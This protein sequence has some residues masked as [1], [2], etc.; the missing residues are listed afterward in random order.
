MAIENNN[1][2]L[3]LAGGKG[4]RL[5]PSSRNDEPKQFLDFFGMGRTQ[6]QQTYDRFA[7]IVPQDHI[8]ISTI[9]NYIHFVVDQLPDVDGNHILAEPVH[10]NTAPSVA[11]ACHRILHFNP[12]ANIIV[13][14]S[15]QT[16]MDEKAF[17]ANI[18]EGLHFVDTNDSLLTL[19]VKP[20]RPEPGY[21]Y[22]QVGESSG[23]DDIYKVKAFTEKPEREFA[24]MFVQSGE[25]Y[26]NTGMFLSNAKYLAKCLKKFLP[27][28]FANFDEIRPDWTIVEENIYVEKHFPSFPNIS[29]D[30][31][32]LEKSDNVYVQKCDFGWADLGT[33]H[34]IYAAENKS[35]NGN[36]TV[37]TKA[38][39]DDARNNVVKLPHDRI[40]VING[41]DGYIVAEK[42]NVLLIC[43][44]GDSSS[45]IKKYVNDIQLRLGEEYV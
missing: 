2:C 19:G 7:Q 37:D 12:N 3:I 8:Y 31:G 18:L 23:E 15:D 45:L 17:K 40:G 26:W 11:W 22:I 33:W 4:R 10:R 24:E 16:V 9:S 21:G 30:Y 36:V 1:F 35:D 39:F 28:V 6:L 38:Y 34:S 5:W 20:T 29:I 42:G 32:I 14:P 43:K 27:V 41:L 13:T 25:W 44:K